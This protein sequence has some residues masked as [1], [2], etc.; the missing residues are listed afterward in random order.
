MRKKDFSVQVLVSTM[1]QTDFSLLETMNIKTSAVVVN[2]CDSDSVK[3]FMY[4]GNT[5]KWINS[6]ERGVGKSRNTALLNATGDILLFADEDVVFV[7]DV[8]QLVVDYFCSSKSDL[9]V[10]NYISLNPDRPEKITKRNHNLH[11]WNCLGYGAFRIAVNRDRLFKKN[12]YYSLLFGGGAKY[13]AGE[14]NLFIT[15]CIKNHMKCTASDNVLG[16]VAQKESTWF[17]GYNDQYYMDRGA[18]FAAMYGK[19]SI[20]MLI[21]FELKHFSKFSISN[22]SYELEGRK[23]FLSNSNV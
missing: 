2:Q 20:I 5:I 4:R 9:A 12:I 6:T 17:N 3:E 16:T 23:L 7:D 14:D 13:Q 11:L 15:Q 18:L 1:H 8:E 22:L 19:A 10:F 21:L